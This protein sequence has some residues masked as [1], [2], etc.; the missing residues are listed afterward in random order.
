MI[1]RPLSLF[2]CLS[3]LCLVALGVLMLRPSLRKSG[4]VLG[5]F[6]LAYPVTDAI[7]AT[8]YAPS[9]NDVNNLT[10]AVNEEGTYGFIFDSSETPDDIY[11]TYNWCNMPHIRTQ[12]YKKASREYKLRYVEV[13]SL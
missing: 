5:V 12:E 11:G 10:K 6:Q 3:S 2:L 8:W 13:V 7:D 4:L 1:S 9:P